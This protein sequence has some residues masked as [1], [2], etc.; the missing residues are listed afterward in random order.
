MA[1][2]TV[3]GLEVHVE[4]KTKTKIF[5]G[6]S[7]DFG[8]EPNTQ[9]CPSCAGFPGTV[10]VLN[11]KAV[12]LAVKAGLSLN[13]EIANY[14][15]FD[16]KNYFY[17]DLPKAYQISQY[18]YP[19]CGKGYIDIDI[20]GESKRIG[21][22]RAHLEE[23]A[24]KLVHQG[25]ITTTTSSLVDLNRSSVP[26]LEIVSE[27][28][29]RSGI[30]ARLYLEKLRS[31]LLF[32]GVS[33][34]KM[35]EGSL[36]CDANVSVRPYGQAEF[37]TRVEIKNLNSFKALEKAIEFEAKRHVDAIE[38]GEELIQETRTWDDEKQV[39]KSMR[40]KE[41]AED[42]RYFPDPDLPPIKLNEAFINDIKENLP[43]LPDEAQK[44]LVEKYNLP[45]YD[46][47]LLTMTPDVLTFF[48]ECMKE[49]ED[50]KVVSNWMMGELTRLLNQNN[51]ELSESKINPEHLINMLQLINK[52]TISGKMAKTVFEEMFNSGKDPEAIIKEKGL[53]QI[54]DEE[55][56]LATIEEVINNNPKVLEDYKAGKE[57]A[58]GFFVGQVM[59]ATK[60][61]ANPAIVNKLLKEKLN[62]E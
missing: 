8:A 53:V 42:Y 34:C 18:D 12:E 59:K 54:S 28:E 44:R 55:T 13:C 22:T 35:Q 17:P 58:F 11:K 30:E 38:D 50:A 62:G 39:T 16:R 52:G 57:K 37:G 10:P 6:C 31:I 61:Q 19:I 29:M 32:A 49:Y 3:I 27:P 40:T 33:D 46:A 24:G 14:S 23:D 47:S 51:I 56:L 48:D 7:T 21:I 25:S 15:K 36:R 1:Y 5:C 20:S 2:E 41:D 9:V 43:E 60:G 45:N 4:L 26:L